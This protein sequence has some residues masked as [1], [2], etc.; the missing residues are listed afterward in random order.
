[1]TKSNDLLLAAEQ[2]EALIKNAKK[3]AS[4]KSVS[5]KELE[6]EL[7]RSKKDYQDH[8]SKHD[9]AKSQLDKLQNDMNSAADHMNN[10]RKTVLKN[11]NVLKN[12]DLSNT[13]LVQFQNNSDDVLYILDKKPFTA[14][15]D[16]SGNCTLV[17]YK[18]IKKIK[19]EPKE[20]AE[21]EEKESEEEESDEDDSDDDECDVNDNYDFLVD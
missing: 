14:T 3:G 6:K 17:P 8:K 12:M 15:F 1:M 18:K 20:D 2:F 19:E 7:I 10:A 5:R 11:H 16:M 9:A 4:K 21:E 13:D